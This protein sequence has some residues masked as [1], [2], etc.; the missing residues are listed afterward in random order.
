MSVHRSKL[1]SFREFSGTAASGSN[2]VPLHD[3]MGMGRSVS[4]LRGMAEVIC[5]YLLSQALVWGSVA[6]NISGVVKDPSGAIIPGVTVTAL[7]TETGIKEVVHTNAQGFY[8]FLSLPVGHYDIEAQQQGF[9]DYRETGLVLDV[10]TALK[11]D[12][13]MALGQVSE[14]VSVTASSVQVDTR[15]TQM[16]EVIESNQITD[17]PLNGRSYIDLLALQPGVAPQQVG[18]LHPFPVSGALGGGNLSISGQRQTNNGFMVNGADVHEVAGMGTAIIPNL[19]SISEF[20]ILTNNVDAEYGNYSG[21]QVNTV[22]KSGGNQIHG[23]AF[24]FVRNT[25]LDSRNFYA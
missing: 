16:G 3:P 7:H 11:I 5:L 15:S 19:D 22:T 8:E 25:D 14:Q 24:E 13:S 9:K 17:I 23:D 1:V 18:G 6:G 12:I 20:R 10:N 2:A 21:G 4:I